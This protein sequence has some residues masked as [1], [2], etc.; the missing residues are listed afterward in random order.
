MQ[1]AHFPADRRTADIRR[2]AQALM[3]IHGEEANR[4]WRAQMSDIAATLAAR[5]ASEEEIAHQASLFMNAVQTELQHL[6]AAELEE[7]EAIDARA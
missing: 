4:Y 5:G 1:I 7:A 3:N 6:F 2:C